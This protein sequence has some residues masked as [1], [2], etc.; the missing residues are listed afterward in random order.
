GPQALAGYAGV[1][2]GHEVGVRARRALARELEHPRAQRGEA[3]LA[4][5]R[6]RGCGVEAV[7]EAAH[8]GQRTAV[9]ARGLRV[10]DAD[11]EHEAPREVGAHGRVGGGGL[12]G[13]VDPDIE[14][15]RR[16]N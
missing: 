9:V 5:R 4:L 12:G 1:L 7:E 6:W 3:A 10:A 14:D 13:I 8:R 15:A 2:D 16:R 11:A